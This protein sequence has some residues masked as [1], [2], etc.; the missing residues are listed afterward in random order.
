MMNEF[1]RERRRKMMREKFRESLEILC[2]GPPNEISPIANAKKMPVTNIDKLKGLELIYHYV[3]SYNE[4]V[5]GGPA[6][7][8][9]AFDS[10]NGTLDVFSEDARHVKV[11]VAPWG[12]MRDYV[13]EAARECGASFYPSEGEILCE[14]MGARARGRDYVEAAMRAWLVYRDREEQSN[15]TV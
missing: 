3:R 5:I 14:M 4:N 1:E 10:T 9:A 8:F 15:R 6:T 13:L 11:Q 2:G 7:V 12:Q